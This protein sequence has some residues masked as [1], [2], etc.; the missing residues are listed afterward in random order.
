[1]EAGYLAAVFGLIG[2]MIGSVS[3]V[4]TMIV[5]ARIRDKRDRSKQVT[6]MALAEFKMKLDLATS[7]KGPPN[8][9]P[10]SIFLYHNDL[11]LEAIESGCFTPEKAREISI[12][13]EKMVKV[14]DEVDGKPRTAQPRT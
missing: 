3:S 6:D 5:Q 12:Q 4:A 1:M 13:A 11:L 8:V 7:G 14:I 9:L 2:A 10:L